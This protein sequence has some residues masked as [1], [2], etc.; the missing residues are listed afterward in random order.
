MEHKRTDKT[1]DFRPLRYL[2][3]HPHDVSLR[4][5]TAPQSLTMAIK[6]A[7]ESGFYETSNTDEHHISTWFDM[8]SGPISSKVSESESSSRSLL[9][10]SKQPTYSVPEATLDAHSRGGRGPA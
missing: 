3:R 8:P 4:N 9:E 2:V 7:V 1:H 10:S 5:S 6:R